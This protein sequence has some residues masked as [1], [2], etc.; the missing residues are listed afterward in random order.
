M[1][2]QLTPGLKLAI[3]HQFKFHCYR[4]GCAVGL[5][6]EIDHLQPQWADGPNS[7]DNLQLLCGSCHNIKSRVEHQYR[8]QYR[9]RP[10]RR[11]ERHCWFCQQVISCYFATTHMCSQRQTWQNDFEQRQ[12]DQSLNLLQPQLFNDIS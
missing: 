9:Q 8:R 7:L 2:K 1:G 10:L 3:A 12:N 4:C 5:G 6:F 11:S